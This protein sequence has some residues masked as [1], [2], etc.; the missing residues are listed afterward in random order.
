MSPRPAAA[1][2]RTSNRKRPTAFPVRQALQRLQDQHRRDHRRRLGPPT[3]PGEQT[4]EQLVGKQLEAMLGQEP[5]HRP[6]LQ[7]PPAHRQSVQQLAIS[8]FRTLRTPKISHPAPKRE[9]F[10][11]ELLSSLLGLDPAG[12]HLVEVQHR[13]PPGAALFV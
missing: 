6:L 7:Q 2:H 5:V 3:P 9:P 4:R 1:F 8:T 11:P 10:R 13:R 12:V